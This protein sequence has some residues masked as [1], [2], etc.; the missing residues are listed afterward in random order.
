MLIRILSDLHTEFAPYVVEELPED[1]DTVLILAGD[2]GLFKHSA[3]LQYLR[4]LSERFYHVIYVAGNHEYYGGQFNYSLYNFKEDF[5]SECLGC[6]NVHILEKESV[7][8]D[9]V[10]FIGATLWTDYKNGDPMVMWD[11]ERMM[12]DYRKIRTGPKDEPWL[13]K[14]RAAEFWADHLAAKDYIFS[15]LNKWDDTYKEVVVT[16]HAPSYQSIAEGFKG[17]PLNNCYTNNLDE[18]IIVSGP[19]VWVHGHMHNTFDYKIGD[20]R[21]IANPKGYPINKEATE[22]EN[23]LFDPKFRIEL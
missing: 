14:V 16:H 13:R 12:N 15:T 22:H 2:I 8:I 21:V 11:A 7:K 18:E 23:S 10:L 19:D 17:H 20:T 6:H 9:D 1:K 3:H 4:E 5:E